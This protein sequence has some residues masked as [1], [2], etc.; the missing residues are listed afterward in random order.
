MSA[1]EDPPHG[2]HCPL[3]EI[4]L[5]FLTPEGHLAIWLQTAGPQTRGAALAVVPAL[6]EV[7]QRCISQPTGEDAVVV[8]GAVTLA[9]WL[10]KVNIAPQ[11][12]QTKGG[13]E[14]ALKVSPQ[15]KVRL[16]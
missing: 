3:E 13:N 5:P 11:I 10:R 7:Y 14:T 15:A 16:A 8:Y 9:L 12:V 4:Q 2:G 1:M 6:R